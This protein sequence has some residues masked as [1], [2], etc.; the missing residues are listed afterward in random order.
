P[1]L[2]IQ[3]GSSEVLLDDAVRLAGAAGAA[4][5][6]VELTIA[7]GLPHVFPVYAPM[8]PEGRAGIAAASQA[9]VRALNG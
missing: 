6:P 1:P 2:Y 4:D 8:L 9:I 7:P 3:A 5:V